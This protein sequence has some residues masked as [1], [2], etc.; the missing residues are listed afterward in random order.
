MQGDRSISRRPTAVTAGELDVGGHLSAGLSIELLGR[1]RLTVEG[2]DGYRFR[3]RKS[4]AVLA[5]LVLGERPPTRAQLATILFPDAD[6]PLGALRWALAEIRKGIGPG[7]SVDGDPVH[8]TLP[9]GTTVDVDV[10]VHGHWRDAVQ[11][12]GAGAELLEGLSVQNA[13]AFD[14]WLIF[15]RRR[16]A[17]A[18]ESILHEAA[19]GH[20]A[21]G[22]L[23]PARDAAVRAA[24]MSPLDENHQALVIRLYRLTGED[25]AAEAQFKAWTVTAQRELGAAPGAGVRLALSERRRAATVDEPAIHAITES[26]AAAVSAGSLGTGVAAF[27]NAVRMADQ[28]AIASLRVTTRLELAG[29]LIHTLGGLDEQGV[30]ILVEAERLAL[31]DGD[32]EAASRAR[33]ELGYVDFLRARYDRAE[34]WLSQALRGS[35][36]PSTRARAMTYLGSV[37]SDQAGYAQA[38]A[39]L[40]EA[41]HLARGARQ[42]RTEAYALSMIGRMDLL[43]GDLTVASERLGLATELAER[44][45]WLS[46]LPWPQALAGHVHLAR[47]ELS[48]ASKCLEQSFAR[49]CQIGDPCWEGI[50]ARGLALLAEASGS[51][52]AAVTMLL[53]ARTRSTRLTD[54]YVWL[55]VHILDALCEVGRRHRDPRTPEWIEQMRHQASRTGMRELT[56][57]AMVHGAALGSRRDV[58]VLEL[59]AASIDNPMLAQAI[60]DVAA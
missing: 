40:E 21:A 50:S 6:D 32:A 29:A 57:R 46:F 9:V 16:V 2:A 48:E 24:V 53:D 58:G 17:A 51:V 12:P 8:L 60:A 30:A 15:Q 35:S 45:H 4:W 34:R 18:T 36:S 26:G 7:G 13:S 52:D 31:A 25:E 54:P 47:G 10:L 19:L 59:F 14:S 56:V 44:E 22:E 27:E 55:E 11:L 43:R 23:G 37:A 33:A 42:P 3:S 38:G 28:A 41:T 20:L 1:P 39:L 5:F 49:A